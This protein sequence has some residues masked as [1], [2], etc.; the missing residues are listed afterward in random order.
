MKLQNLLSLQLLMLASALHASDAGTL[1]SVTQN[2]QN[3]QSLVTGLPPANSN[4]PVVTNATLL[5]YKNTTTIPV[6]LSVTADGLTNNQQIAPGASY[7]QNVLAVSKV[8]LQVHA[9]LSPI[10]VANYTQAAAYSIDIKQGY[11]ALSQ[12]AATGATLVNNSSW[13]VIVS[14]G[15]AN[16]SSEETILQPAQ[17]LTPPAATINVTIIPDID[18]VVQAISSGKSCTIVNNKGSL[19]FQF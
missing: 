4:V 14:F 9:Y 2:L 8:G 19:E 13:P 17:R 6:V 15:Y 7:S 18:D 12:T 16:N 1:L 10:F 11:L 5:S 3:K